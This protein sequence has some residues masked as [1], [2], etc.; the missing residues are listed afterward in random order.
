ME[1]NAPKSFYD[2]LI[3]YLGEK[4]AEFIDH[5]TL[6]IRFHLRVTRPRDSK[7]GDYRPAF[8][9][10]QQRIT[11][12]G[13]LDK[14]SFLITLLHELAHL[15][16]QENIKHPYLPHGKEWKSSFSELLSLAVKNEI[17]PTDISRLVNI[18]YVQ[19]KIFTQSSRNK[20]QVAIN[21]ELGIKPN[22][23]LNEIPINGK[24]L[25]QNGMKV[26]KI[27]N[28]RTRCLCRNLENNQLYLI[29]N[30]IETISYI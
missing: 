21:K 10:N 25:L 8:K 15:Y 27:K 5:L 16:V 6:H 22:P 3:P 29:Q 7:Y 2:H 24:V 11:I 26:I 1:K 4:A 20:I 18:Y 13:N 17:F 12:N 30:Y 9:N 23:T 14:Y 28:N 19:K